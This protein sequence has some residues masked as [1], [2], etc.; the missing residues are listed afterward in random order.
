MRAVGAFEVCWDGSPPT[1]RLRRASASRRART[2]PVVGLVLRSALREGGMVGPAGVAE[3]SNTNGLG[4]QTCES[5]YIDSQ[6]VFGRV[7]NRVEPETLP[8]APS[9]SDLY[10][11]SASPEARIAKLVKARELEQS[12]R[13][14]Q[15][16]PDHPSTH[17]PNHHFRRALIAA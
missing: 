8:T 14:G 11:A 5:R 1:P 3:R 17:V 16:W 13:C 15:A 10:S 9:V 12:V 6:G 4:W 2:E 7:A